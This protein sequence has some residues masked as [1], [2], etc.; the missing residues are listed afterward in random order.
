MTVDSLVKNTLLTDEHCYW[1]CKLPEPGTDNYNFIKQHLYSIYYAGYDILPLEK[2]Q[3][4]ERDLD[5]NL[6]DH[7]NP[8]GELHHIGVPFAIADYENV[9]FNLI[10]ETRCF[11]SEDWEVNGFI[12]WLS[13]KTWRPLIVGCPFILHGAVNSYQFLESMGFNTYEEFHGYN[14]DG[15]VTIEETANKI[16][17]E[18]PAAIKRMQAVC[19]SDAGHKKLCE[20]AQHNKQL[21]RELFQSE[22][23]KFRDISLT[24]AGYEDKLNLLQTLT[25]IYTPNPH[26]LPEDF[27]DINRLTSV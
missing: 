11:G 8:Y 23:D 4:Y 22:Y 24:V 27:F 17:T 15:V 16:Y 5:W 25:H 3:A 10:T 7:T 18:L 26:N 12:N 6:T 14:T 19:S 20:I 9:G 1:S 21:T 2:L 13:E